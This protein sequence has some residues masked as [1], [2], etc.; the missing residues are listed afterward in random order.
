MSAVATQMT[1][2]NPPSEDKLPT[3]IEIEPDSSTPETVRAVGVNGNVVTIERGVYSGGVGTEHQD[4]ST[5]KQK[6]SQKHWDA[7][8][9][10]LDAGFLTVDGSITITR[11][12][13]TQFTIAD[14][15]YTAYFTEDRVIR[16]NG[17]S[18]YIFVVSGSSLSTTD[19]VV[20]IKSGTLPN[21]L[22]SVSLAIQPMG[23]TDLFLNEADIAGMLTESG[24]QSMSNKTIVTPKIITAHNAG[25]LTGAAVI[26][27]ANGDLQ[28]GVLTGN[29]TLDFSNMV[30]GQR[31]TLFLAED[32]TGGRTIA[33]TPTI[34]WQD[35]TVPTWVTTA[36]K[37]NVM[38]IYCHSVD[39]DPA[40]NVYYGMGA[41][42][43]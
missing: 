14:Q 1:V 13:N 22:T 21:P 12:S 23:A 43:A 32:E 16:C 30:A 28:K 27:W 19:T 41:K 35:N 11:D 18:S 8:V 7:I 31:L 2:N 40:N 26:N 20:T 10:A 17:S 9:E 6:F 37:M 15:D 4:N 25:N 29:V 5:Y 38:V 34:I 42:F 39:A 3:N 24:T 36:S 33:F